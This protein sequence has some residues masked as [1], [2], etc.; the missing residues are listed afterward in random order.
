M[1]ARSVIT[2]FLPDILRTGPTALRRGGGNGV[3]RTRYPVELLLRVVG[4]TVNREGVADRIGSHF[5]PD[6][7]WRS[8]FRR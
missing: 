3:T 7:F 8:R 2:P 1:R 5:Y 6:H 4:H